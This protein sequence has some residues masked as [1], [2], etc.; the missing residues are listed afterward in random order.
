MHKADSLSSPGSDVVVIRPA[1]PSG[2]IG[3]AGGA[4]SWPPRSNARLRMRREGLA[5][6]IL[7]A[8]ER[9]GLVRERRQVRDIVRVDAVSQRQVMADEGAGVLRPV[10][11][12]ATRS[13]RL[14]AGNG[15]NDGYS[16]LSK[17]ARIG[18]V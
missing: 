3:G 2:S 17:P 16:W 15:P 12:T 10:S 14:A 4:A 13:L 1:T 9:I 18:D 6:R 8:R 5:L 7:E 11:S